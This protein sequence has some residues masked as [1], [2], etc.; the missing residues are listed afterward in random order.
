MKIKLLL[1]AHLKE[2]IG[3]NPITLDL[4][5]AATG[6]VLLD[7]L[8][9]KYPAAEKHKSSLR[10]SMNGEYITPDDI[11]VDSSEVAVFPPV[12]GGSR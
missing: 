8:I 6:Q 10:L 3:S 5:T 12:S 1:F 7:R 4:P 9:E 11:I 2:I